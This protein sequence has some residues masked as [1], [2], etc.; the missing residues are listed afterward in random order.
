MMKVGSQSMTFM[1]D[2]GAERAMVTTPLAPLTGKTA[3]IAG[4]EDH[5]SLLILQSP[6]RVN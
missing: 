4:A 5:D 3:A 2:T 6:I 1:V